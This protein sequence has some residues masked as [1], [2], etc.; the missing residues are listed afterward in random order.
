MFESVHLLSTASDLIKNAAQDFVKAGADDAS[1]KSYILNQI[2]ERNSRS[3]NRPTGNS[4]DYVHLLEEIASRYTNVDEH[5]FFSVNWSDEIEY[6]LIRDQDTIT[7]KYNVAKTLS[8]SGVAYMNPIDLR[9][10]KF[11]FLPSWLH[12]YL[13]SSRNDRVQKEYEAAKAAYERRYG[14][15][16]S[17]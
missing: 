9:N 13:V 5:G 17:N 12:E 11:R 8:R 7:L 16:S 6:T 10:P 2:L 4:L 14:S 3:H 1:I 15:V